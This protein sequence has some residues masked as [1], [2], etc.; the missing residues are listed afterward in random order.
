MKIPGINRFCKTSF[1]IIN[2][3]LIEFNT[4]LCDLLT[5]SFLVEFKI[6]TSL[7]YV[8]EIAKQNGFINMGSVIYL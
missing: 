7:S 4:V 6:E 2:I 8:D 1:F 3:Y 5:S